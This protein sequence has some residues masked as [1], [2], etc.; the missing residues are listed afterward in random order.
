MLCLRLF[1]SRDNEDRRR[2]NFGV[3]EKVVDIFSH[4]VVLCS[5]LTLN[6]V[7]NLQLYFEVAYHIY[8]VEFV[9]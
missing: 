8:L 3:S 7:T 6:P 4:H 1:Q 9:V 2:N 5:D